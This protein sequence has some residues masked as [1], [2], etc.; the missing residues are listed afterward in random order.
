MR[1]FFEVIRRL[2]MLARGR[3][4]DEDLREEMELHMELRRQQH[5][6][7]GMPPGEAKAAAQRRFGN[8]MLMREQSRD[9]WGWAW[10]E[11]SAQDVRYGVRSMMRNPGFTLV[12]V[13]ILAM[14]AGAST[15]VFSVVNSVLLHPLS[16]A[17]PR[18]LVTLLHGGAAPVSAANYV[19]W[20][21]QTDAFAAVGAAEYWSPNLTG[22]DAPENIRALRLTQNLLPM[23]GVEPMIGRVFAVGEDQAGAERVAVLSHAL[24]RR[25]FAENRGVV[26]R[27]I[28][29]DGVPFTVVGVMP[30]DFQFAPFWATRT[31]L[32]APLALGG[33]VWDRGGNSLRVFARLKPGVSLQQ[34]REN[35]RA[36]TARLESEFPGSNRDVAVTPLLENVTGSVQTPLL[37]VMGAVALVLLIACAN[38]AHMLLARAAARQKEIAVR[39]AMGAGGWRLIRQFLV[40][41]F[42]LA[43]CGAVAGLLFAAWAVR[44][45]AAIG[46]ASIPR[47]NTVAI[48]SSVLLFS[49][50][51]TLLTG[52]AFSLAPVLHT[53]R[54]QLAAALKQGARAAGGS[55]RLS[56]ARSLLSASEIALAFMLLIGAG[57]LLR[58]FASLRA[59][60]PGFDPSQVLSMVVSLAGSQHAEPGKREMFY[61]RVVREVANVPGIAP[62]AGS[63][64]C[65]WRATSGRCRS[66]S[67]DARNPGR[68]SLQRPST[69]S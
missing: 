23:L 1:S 16:Y 66:S 8:V 67:R 50:A 28:L 54:M 64:I 62:P 10:I 3:R 40:E 4:F 42:L 18:R 21:D 33:R 55:L 59:I 65:L 58:S 2:T 49:V 53:R 46:P 36:V 19:D 11:Q 13:M 56:Q 38:V 14:G 35:L 57:L 31:E 52:I 29:L 41:G 51:I 26:G 45:L 60:D 9:G 44:V 12:A 27:T 20:R 63:T 34:A 5:I 17:E 69:G 15:A 43:G 30:P 61:R 47:L 22:I 32:W 7:Q 48:D 39:S 37:V 68:A 24:W 25:R 6:G